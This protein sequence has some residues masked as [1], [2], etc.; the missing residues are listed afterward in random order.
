MVTIEGVIHHLDPNL[1]LLELARPYLIKSISRK[2]DPIKM[3]KKVLAG[4][5]DFGAYMEDF[6][7]DFKN[8]IKKINT[9]KIN[10]DLTHHGVDPMVHT[11]NRVTR[12][13]VISLVICS[14]IIG[15]TLLMINSVKPLWG[16][17]SVYGIIGVIAAVYLALRMRRDLRK[18][19]HD[20]W[21]GWD[22]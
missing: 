13:L 5:Y 11:I 22:E 20:D 8:A 15:S 21:S 2:L 7:Q 9:G 19:D 6:P 16:Q 14:L 17:T 10:V 18:G 3:I 1:N 4:L 12:Q